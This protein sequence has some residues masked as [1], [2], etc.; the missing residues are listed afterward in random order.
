MCVRERVLLF[1]RSVKINVIQMY[2]SNTV[3]VKEDIEEHYKLQEV[4][5]A[6][7]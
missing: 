7:V 6:V 2:A 4:Q 1:L 3:L 5:D